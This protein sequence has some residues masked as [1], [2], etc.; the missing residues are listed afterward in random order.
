MNPALLFGALLIGATCAAGARYGARVGLASAAIV[1]STPT[2]LSQIVQP[3]SH[4]P[5][6]AL[7]LTAVAAV[8]AGRNQGAVIGGIAAAA[9]IVMRPHLVPLVIPLVLFLLLRPERL[10][11]ERIGAVARF[12]AAAAAGAVCVAIIR[13]AFDGSPF[14]SGYE[15]IDAFFNAQ[16]VAPNATRYAT[17]L[18]E[19]LTPGW[20]L[21]AAA[22]FLLPGALTRLF[23]WMFLV[24][25]ACNLPYA[26]ADDW[27]DLRVLLPTIPLVVVLAIAVIDSLCRRT[28]SWTS[29]PVL[30]AVAAAMVIFGIRARLFT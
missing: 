28:W 17:W 15:S 30:A 14:S 20:V 1:A 11:R 18:S 5:A 3:V 7:W 4:V 13:N 12:A 19:T 26:V 24:N 9:A 10:W 23:L 8:T 6:A 27:S 16:N 25:V 2:F 21:V 29:R 22:P